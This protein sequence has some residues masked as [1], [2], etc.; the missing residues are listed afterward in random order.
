MRFIG[1]VL[2]VLGM[3]S[4]AFAG[5]SGSVSVYKWVTDSGTFAFTDDSKNIP[6]KYRPKVEL[7]TVGSVRDYEKYT[8]VEPDAVPETEITKEQQNILDQ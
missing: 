4:V 6:P 7:L 1:V 8:H 5:E 2:L 3:S